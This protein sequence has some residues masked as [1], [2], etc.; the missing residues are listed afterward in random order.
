MEPLFNCA[1]YRQRMQHWK[2]LKVL[3]GI[4]CMVSEEGAIWMTPRNM[5]MFIVLPEGSTLHCPKQKEA[6]WHCMVNGMEK[7]LKKPVNGCLLF[8]SKT[9]TSSSE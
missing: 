5:K 2:S 7:T 6:R 9:K 3:Q 4:L 8:A 1:S